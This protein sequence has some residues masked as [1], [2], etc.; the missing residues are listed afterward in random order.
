MKPVTTEHAKDASAGS[1]DLAAA[2]LVRFVSGWIKPSVSLKGPEVNKSDWLR[3]NG[4]RQ[5][6]GRRGYG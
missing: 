4:A 3:G 1:M 2:S 6:N 5:I